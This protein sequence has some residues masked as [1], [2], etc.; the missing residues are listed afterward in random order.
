MVSIYVKKMLSFKCE[1]YNISFNLA[2]HL[3]LKY[4]VLFINQI[5][6]NISKF[7]SPFIIDSLH[8][9]YIHTFVC[10]ITINYNKYMFPLFIDSC[11]F[12]KHTC[13]QQLNVCVSRLIRL[14]PISSIIVYQHIFLLHYWQ[15]PLMFV[16]HLFRIII[17][18]IDQLV[19]MNPQ[20]II[21]INTSPL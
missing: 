17:I 20:A 13:H 16:C 19:N 6:L 21:V 3:V 11:S 1:L 7:F 12:H 15:Y 2:S 10:G 4:C 9:Y 18:P 8:I 5:Y 14:R